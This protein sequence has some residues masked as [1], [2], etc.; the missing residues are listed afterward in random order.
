MRPF[1]IAALVLA[2]ALLVADASSVMAQETVSVEQGSRVR[3]TA[4]SLGLSESVGTI[5]EATDEAY[6]VQFEF[7]RVLGSVGRSDIAAMDV[8]VGRER[9]GLSGL[10][11]GLLVGAGVGALF[12]F[13][14]GDDDPQLW[15]SYTAEQKALMGAAGL[16]VVGGVIGML[17]RKNVWSSALPE[18]VD[19][20][21]APLVR[22]GGVGLQVGF[23][24]RLN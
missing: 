12:G 13:L 16:G 1:S 2:L 10:G 9:R 23:G 21:V 3:I 24:I 4:P 20:T 5:Q 11:R 19:L 22:P 6:V 17:L 7:P 15:F 18:D 14:A 8:L